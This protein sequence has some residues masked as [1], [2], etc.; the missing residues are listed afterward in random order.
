MNVEAQV[1][2]VPT[3]VQDYRPAYYGGVAAIELR[4]DG[5]RRM[6]IDVDPQEL[7]RRHRARLH[8]RARISPARTTGRS[9]SAT[10]TAT[11]TCSSASI[12][13]W[14]A[15]GGLRD[16]LDR[17]DWAG[18]ARADQRWNGR[19]ARRWRQA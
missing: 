5:V 3:G 15:T 17:G 9:S 12:A 1:I 4:P 18:V 16:A 6:A 2:K 7:Q 10:S 13:S 8:R 19:R 11:A 14:Q